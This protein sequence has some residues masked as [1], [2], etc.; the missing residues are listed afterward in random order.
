MKMMKTLLFIF[1]LYVLPASAQEISNARIDTAQNFIQKESC[2]SDYAVLIDMSHPSNQKRWY[3][4]DLKNKKVVYESY[5]AHGR[6]SGQGKQATNFSDVPGSY[7]TALGCYKITGTY[8]GE[9]GLSYQLAGLEQTNKNA[10]SRAIVIHSAWYADDNF[11]ASTGRCGNSW[12]CPAV[13]AT[14]LK[15]CAPYLKPN[16]L[17]WIYN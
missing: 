17:V 14:A 11:I 15:N 8:N 9:H 2:N 6:G 4:V 12:G 16:T 3:V 13:S 10:M 7:C 1:T 5:V